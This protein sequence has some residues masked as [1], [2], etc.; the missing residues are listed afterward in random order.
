MRK[1]SEKK[2]RSTSLRMTENQFAVIEQKAQEK[3]MSV[4]SYMID[5]AVHGSNALTPVLLVRMQDIV[6]E[7]CEIIA[8]DDPDKAK[9]MEQEAHALWC[10]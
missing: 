6:N 2:N 9:R 3:G 10:L 8:T 1:E 4:S 7:A 5:S